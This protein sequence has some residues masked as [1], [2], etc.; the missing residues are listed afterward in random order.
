VVLAGAAP[1]VEAMILHPLVRDLLNRAE[2]L[3]GAHRDQA[4]D[5]LR[6]KIEDKV[7]L[8]EAG[9]ASRVQRA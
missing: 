1:E 5:H 7:R 3:H 9:R 4:L 6:A 2:T 8:D